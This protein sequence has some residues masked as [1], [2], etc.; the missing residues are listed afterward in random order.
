MTAA[1]ITRTPLTERLENLLDYMTQGAY[2]PAFCADCVKGLED[3]CGHCAQLEEDFAVLNA[4]IG[5]VQQAAD[6]DAALAVYLK[7]VM[8]LTGIYPASEVRS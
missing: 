8:R 2:P 4:A 1:T 3:R 6:E 7:T 5:K